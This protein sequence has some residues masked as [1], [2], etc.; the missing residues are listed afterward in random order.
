MVWSPAS[1]AERTRA[2]FSAVAKLPSGERVISGLLL[3]QG[4]ETRRLR[5][6]LREFPLKNRAKEIDR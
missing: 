1:E 6:R 4:L 5:F 2:E 3:V